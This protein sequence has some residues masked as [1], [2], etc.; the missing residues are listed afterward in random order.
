[1]KS[2]H[3]KFKFQPNQSLNS[4][5]PSRTFC[6]SAVRSFTCWVWIFRC[7]LLSDDVEDCVGVSALY[8]NLLSKSVG[9]SET[10]FPGAFAIKGFAD[11][12][13]EDPAF[14]LEKK[15]AK[16]FKFELIRS[17]ATGGASSD[18]GFFCDIK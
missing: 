16:A 12:G 11:E 8:W 7:G 5:R 15:E 2:S 14:G 4:S 9:D 13:S 3:K 10:T 18:F 17:V 1:M 6:S